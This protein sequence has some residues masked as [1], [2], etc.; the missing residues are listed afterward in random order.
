MFTKIMGALVISV[1][2]VI[3]TL[4]AQSVVGSHGT[5]AAGKPH[6]VQATPQACKVGGTAV[7]GNG[8]TGT[9]ATVN[10]NTITVSTPAG[11]TVTVNVSS[12]TQYRGESGASSLSAIQTGTVV[13]VRGTAGPNNSINATYIAIVPPHA[14]GKVTAINGS[15]L[16]VQPQSGYLG[17]LASSVTTVITNNNTQYFAPGSATADLNTIKVGTYVAATGTLNSGGKSLTATKI[18]IAPAGFSPGNGG[19]APHFMMRGMLR[20][21]VNGMGIG[22]PFGFHRLW[23]NNP[24]GAHSSWGA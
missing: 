22:G 8:V 4:I 5:S 16:T 17:N 21:I 2:S 13:I 7:H 10:G 1:V 14:A 23:T 19:F 20:G 9:V 3:T 6:Q 18:I 11:K 24:A 15:T 12:S